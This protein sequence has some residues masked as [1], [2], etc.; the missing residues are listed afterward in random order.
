MLHKFAA[1]SVGQNGLGEVVKIDY[2]APG[3]RAINA[4]NAL[5]YCT[6]VLSAELSDISIVGSGPIELALAA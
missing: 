1:E 4:G 5:Q 6:A 3:W 2:S